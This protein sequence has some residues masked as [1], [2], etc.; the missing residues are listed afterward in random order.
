MTRERSEGFPYRF[1]DWAGFGL[2][3][4][5]L[6][7][8]QIVMGVTA[9]AV[10]LALLTVANI[11]HLV[12]GEGMADSPANQVLRLITLQNGIAQTTMLVSLLI[13]VALAS[14]VS[15]VRTFLGMRDVPP[16]PAPRK[17]PYYR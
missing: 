7:G 15:F 6:C 14:L 9:Y 17:R 10:A 1:S 5:I 13:G 4:G 11:S 3:F 12:R 2:T 8:T 16:E